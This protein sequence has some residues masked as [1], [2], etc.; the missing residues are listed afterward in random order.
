MKMRVLIV[1]NRPDDDVVRDIIRWIKDHFPDSM[2]YPIDRPEYTPEVVLSHSPDVMVIDVALT[3]EDEEYFDALD[4]E[5]S[6]FDSRREI[7]GIEYCRKVKANFA[8]LPVLLASK[9]FNPQILA[10]AIDAGA[11]G[12]LYKE[13][14][15]E[16]HFIS[17][18]KATFF[19]CKTDDVA[20]YEDLRDLLEDDATEA[21]EREHMLGAMDAFFTRGSGTRRLTG[22][23]CNLAELVE[24]VLPSEAVDELLRALMDTEALLLTANPRMRDHVRHA[25]NVFWL[26]YYLLN[27]LPAF[28]KPEDLP[29]YSPA[30]YQGSNML[31]FKQINVAWLLAALL[32]DIGYLRERIGKVEARLDRGRSLFATQTGKA[33]SAGRGKLLAP[34]GLDVLQPRLKSMGPNGSRLYSAIST[35]LDKWGQSSPAGKIIEDHGIASASAFLAALQASPSAKVDEPQLLHAAAAIALHN[36]AKWNKHWPEAGGPVPLPVGLLPSAWLLGYCDELQGWGREPEIDPFDAESPAERTEARRKYGEGYMKGSRITFF[37]TD[38]IP[39][40]YF[41]TKVDIRIQY[42]MVHGDS[43]KAVSGDVR[44]AIQNWKR[45]TAPVLRETL[46]LDSLLETTITHWVPG[47]ISQP[48]EVKLDARQSP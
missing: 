38:D 2:C 14:L 19:R 32:H 35:T 23:W 18:L 25:G 7:S 21:W 42:M 9:H 12:F 30:T 20:F 8:N 24:K 36:L 39:A 17:A 48:I 4:G 45:D 40:G 15:Y 34:V 46:G 37:E 1:D 44:E 22:L 26:G 27:K 13:F 6:K 41:K 28:R 3:D 10:A 47:P 33:K 43:A 5:E 11:D 29:G 16:E 31:P